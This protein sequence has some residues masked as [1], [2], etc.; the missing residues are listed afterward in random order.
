[1]KR[2]NSYIMAVPGDEKEKGEKKHRVQ[3]WLKTFQTQ[4]VRWA[5]R[6]MKH[7]DLK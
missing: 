3:D 5:S 1:M 2:N 4:G 7:K 6:P